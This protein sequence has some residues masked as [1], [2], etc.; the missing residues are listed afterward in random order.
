MAEWLSGAKH[1]RVYLPEVIFL[2]KK[3]YFYLQFYFYFMFTIGTVY[4]W[5]PDQKR[6]IKKFC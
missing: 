2:S 5:N 6:K 3:Y 1:N 4:T